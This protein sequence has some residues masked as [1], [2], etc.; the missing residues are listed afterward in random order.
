MLLPTE[1]FA[2]GVKNWRSPVSIVD[3]DLVFDWST[4]PEEIE[5]PRGA[6]LAVA[7]AGVKTPEE[8]QRYAAQWGWL[9]LKRDEGRQVDPTMIAWMREPLSEWL[10]LATEVR[11]VIHLNQLLQRA[12]SHEALV[13]HNATE[14]LRRWYDAEKLPEVLGPAPPRN[15]SF[16]FCNLIARIMAQTLTNR[17]ENIKTAV[18]VTTKIEPNAPAARFIFSS[19]PNQGLRAMIFHELAT[20]VAS[21]IKIGECA[22]DCG[23]P[24]AIKHGNQRYFHPTHANAARQQ[25]FVQKG[26]T[27]R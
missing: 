27:P 17:L 11:E 16:A 14:T 10:G 20:L 1:L 7:F 4:R 25:K 3:G 19:S 18:V 15:Q 9:G 21:Q 6:D 24:F 13:S 22:C 12:T 5:L 26:S 23:R 2:P 8:A